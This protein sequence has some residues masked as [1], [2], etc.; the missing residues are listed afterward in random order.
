MYLYSRN[1]FVT[2]AHK[3]RKL[4]FIFQID[5][6]QIFR[7]LILSYFRIIMTCTFKGKKTNKDK[8]NL[9]KK[10]LKSSALKISKYFFVFPEGVFRSAKAN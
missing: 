3:I 2:I 5:F 1:Y 8:I 4:K 9:A 7:F 6:T 10:N